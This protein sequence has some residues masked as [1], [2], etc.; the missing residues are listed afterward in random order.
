MGG[1]AEQSTA[2]LP[3]H[4]LEVFAEAPL[5]GNLH[6]VVHEADAVRDEAM[7]AF[8]ARLRLSETSYVT[9][10]RAAADYRH[11]IFTKAGEIPFAGHPSLGTAVAVAA[12][13]SG[14]SARLVQET[15]AGLQELA[16][17]LTADATAATAEIWQNPPEFLAEVDPAPVLRSCGLTDRDGD[18]TLPAA[19]VS[20]GLA[21]LIVPV[22]DT[23]VLSRA[24]VDLAAL[25]AALGTLPVAVVTVYLVAHHSD[26]NFVA[27]CFTNQ[28]AGGEDAATGSAAGPL[29]ALVSRELGL[30]QISVSQGEAIGSPS[31]LGARL[32]GDRVVVSGNVRIVGEGTIELPIAGG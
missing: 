20:T 4:F 19:V 28:V 17:E 31:R 21:T 14:S 25:A 12:R 29:C 23:A 6:A 16:V 9:T 18:E 1:G 15:G 26:A 27:R 2:R 11:R 8:A 22:G 10:S 3:V 30:G 24:R 32:D 13:R 7:A 5:G